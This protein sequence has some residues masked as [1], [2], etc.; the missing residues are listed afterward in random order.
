MKILHREQPHLVLSTTGEDR[1]EGLHVSSIIKQW[2]FEQDRKFNPDDPMD[3]M[4][5]EAGHTW[6][7]ILSSSLATRHRRANEPYAGHRPGAIQVDGIWGSPDW[8]DPDFR[9]PLEE[10]KAT[11]AHTKWKLE[12]K[13]WYWLPQVMAYL[14]MLLELGTVTIPAALLRVWYING[15]YSYKS[16][17]DDLT[18]LRDYHEFEL[19][20][21]ARELKENWLK[22]NRIADKYAMR[23]IPRFE[24]EDTCRSSNQ[25]KTSLKR[26]RASKP[27]ARSSGTRMITFPATRKLRS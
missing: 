17:F 6:E 16:Q 19:T 22:L 8:I 14:Y 10:W 1:P 15:D 11:K 13:H 3:M 20:F 12:E 25:P 5:I 27:P 26:K 23:G 9:W 21:S 18:L 2:M 24:A 4:R 7:E